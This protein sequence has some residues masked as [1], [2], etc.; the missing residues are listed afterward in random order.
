[1][2]LFLSPLERSGGDSFRHLLSLESGTL[3]LIISV[4]YLNEI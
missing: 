2:M 1:M 3:Y 4:E